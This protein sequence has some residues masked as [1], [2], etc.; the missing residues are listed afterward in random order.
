MEDTTETTKNM[1]AS[2]KMKQ[3]DNPYYYNGI[4][5]IESA[6]LLETRNLAMKKSLLYNI[7]ICVVFVSIVFLLLLTANGLP[8][9]FESPI[10]FLLAVILLVVCLLLQRM[11]RYRLVAKMA[12]SDINELNTK[13]QQKQEG[14]IKRND[15]KAQLIIILVVVVGFIVAVIFMK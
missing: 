10:I 6:R 9:R 13:I 5:P 1:T 12:A 2:E 3:I 8:A 11:I 4:G 15:K 7:L 14:S